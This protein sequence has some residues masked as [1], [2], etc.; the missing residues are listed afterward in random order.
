V[1]RYA[2]KPVT[3]VANDIITFSLDETT[4]GAEA[5]LTSLINGL[6]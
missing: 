1:W 6:P 4:V 5:S 2:I 3:I